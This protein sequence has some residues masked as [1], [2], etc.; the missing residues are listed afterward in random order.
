MNDPLFIAVQE[1]V[2]L[3]IQRGIE[4]RPLGDGF[5]IRLASKEVAENMDATTVRSE[6]AW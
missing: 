5:Y 3:V 4:V 1:A 2:E 6:R